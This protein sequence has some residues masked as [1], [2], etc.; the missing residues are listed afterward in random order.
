MSLLTIISFI[1]T[2]GVFAGGLYLSSEDVGIFYDQ[3]SL[4]IVV[5]GSIA[6]SAVA[7]KL[8]KLFTLFKVFIMR[9]LSKDMSSNENLVKELILT[10]DKLKKGGAISEA[11]NNSED[12]FLKEGLGLVED[13]LLEKSDLLEVLAD[14][15]SFIAKSYMNETS[16]LKAIGKFPPAFGMVGTTIGMVVLLANLGGEDAMKKI[17]PAMGVCLITTLYGAAIANLFLIPMAENLT[18]STKE[19]FGKNEIIIEGIRL[20]LDKANP[21]FAAEKLNSFLNPAQRVDWKSIIQR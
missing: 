9:V 3:T 17:G 11:I 21:I 6:A 20:I 7:F 18:Q 12:H 15:N 5:G 13:G 16:K 8:N 10:I 2:I 1:L 4:F 19:T 14:R